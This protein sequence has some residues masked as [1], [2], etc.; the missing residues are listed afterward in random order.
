M[1]A[2]L[3]SG[4]GGDEDVGGEVHVDPARRRVQW[5]PRD[6]RASPPRPAGCRQEA[7]ARLERRVEVIARARTGSMPSR[8]AA[9]ITT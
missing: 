2:E 5:Q 3:E 9:R 7:A 1:V 8:S 6:A 4:S